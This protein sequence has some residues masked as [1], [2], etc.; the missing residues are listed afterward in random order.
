MIFLSHSLVTQ[1]SL[2]MPI[3]AKQPALLIANVRYS[4]KVAYSMVDRVKK[5]ALFDI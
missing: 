4:V 2:P 5:V 3:T 1:V